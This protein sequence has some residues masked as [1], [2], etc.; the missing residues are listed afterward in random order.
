M[1]GYVGPSVEKM[2]YSVEE[3]L[4]L[5]LRQV[6]TPDSFKTASELLSSELAIADDT[7][8]RA[9]TVFELELRRKDGTTFRAEVSAGF[10]R[11]KYNRPYG[12]LGIAREIQ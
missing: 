4:R 3:G 5:N 2:G 6:V 7:A 1:P 10:L 9:A 11:D 8:E 12:L